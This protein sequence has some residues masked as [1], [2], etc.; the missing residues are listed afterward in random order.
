[1]AAAPFRGKF[2]RAK[3][4]R[5]AAESL[6]NIQWRKIKC[7]SAFVA[8]FQISIMMSPQNAIKK[9]VKLRFRSDPGRLQH[10][11]RSASTHAGGA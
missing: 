6:A 4:T 3:P 10:G 9:Y 1:L 8:P 11:A 2:F 7:V 5:L